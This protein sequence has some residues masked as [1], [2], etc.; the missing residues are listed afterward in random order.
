[1]G[2]T[3]T[4]IRDALLQRHGTTF[5][6]ELG[7]HP[8]HD[9]PAPLFRWLCAALLMSARISTDIALNAARAL[10]DAGW[11]TADKM[12][13]SRW[14]DRVKVL[15]GAGYARYDE[16]T[17]RMLGESSEMLRDRYDGDLRQLREEA[18]RDPQAERRLLKEFKG[19]GDV[20][21]DIFFREVQTAWDELYPFADARALKIADEMGLPDTAEGLARLAGRDRLPALLAALIRAD[22]AGDS[23]EDILQAA[24]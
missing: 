14:E 5:A 24:K 16:S 2:E 19:I 21:A 4:D 22:L 18:D 6:E 20:G 17:A 13:D 11:T 23:R 1:M 12:A 8:E 10:A 3:Q 9:T 7:I 15:N